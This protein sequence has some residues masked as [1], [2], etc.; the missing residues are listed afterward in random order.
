LNNFVILKNL[1]LKIKKGEFIAVV[2][3]VGS[4][5]SSLLRALIGDMISLEPDIV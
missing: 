3:D 1:D 5:K 2:G 4:G